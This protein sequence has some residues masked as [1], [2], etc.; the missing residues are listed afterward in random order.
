MLSARCARLSAILDAEL[1]PP[2]GGGRS[3]LLEEP[4][5]PAPAEE[6]AAGFLYR[7][8]RFFFRRGT[9]LPRLLERAEASLAPP[10]WRGMAWGVGAW[11][12]RRIRRAVRAHKC[13]YLSAWVHRR[14]CSTSGLGRYA[15][16]GVR[17]RSYATRTLALVRRPHR[18]SCEGYSPLSVPP[19]RPECSSSS[20]NWAWGGSA[21]LDPSC[22][23]SKH[24][25]LDRATTEHPTLAA[26]FFAGQLGSPSLLPRR[27][28]CRR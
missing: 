10:A 2:L 9:A 27:R 17:G 15:R 8:E 16:R 11:G 18:G 23:R 6:G 19:W 13:T 26:A 1:R 4:P 20:A 24:L 25:S 12:G 22:V 5:R 21:W 7:D 3:W 28:H 14:R